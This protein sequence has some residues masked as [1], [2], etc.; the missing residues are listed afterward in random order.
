[1]KAVVQKKFGGPEVLSHED[2][3]D[4]DVGPRDALVRVGA[5]ALNRLDV[6][7]RQGPPLLPGFALPHIVGMDVAGT[8]VEVGNQ[9][10]SFTAGD[11]VLVNPA[12][13]CGECDYCRSGDDSFCPFVKVVGGTRPGGYA[14][15]CSV[16]GDHLYRL[17][18]NVD[19]EEAATIPTAYST[20]WHAIVAVGALRIG[21]TLLVHGAG[22]GVTIAAIQ[23]AKRCG[24]RVI[25][26]ARSQEKLELAQRLGADGAVNTSSEDLAVRC[27]ELTGGRGVDIAFDHVGPDLFQ[28]TIL[29]LRPRGRV[30]FAGTTTGAEARF[31][32]AHAYHFGVALLGVDPYGTT[33]FGQMLDF[34]WQGGFEPVI[35]SRFALADAAAAQARMESGEAVGKILLLP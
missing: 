33:E 21:E 14:E 8:I 3:A 16:P 19:F 34:Y 17:P 22:S 10:E 15:L 6:L 2:V 4:P 23:I 32:L 9:V 5:A 28:Q 29:S 30:V 18:E 20:A 25:V 31:D 26:T 35:D 13:E 1:M 27:R 24:A 11:R 7:Q 12:L